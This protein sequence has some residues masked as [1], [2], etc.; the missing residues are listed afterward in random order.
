MTVRELE[1]IKFVGPATIESLRLIGYKDLESLKNANPDEMYQRERILRGQPIDRCQLYVY[2]YLVYI[3]NTENPEPKK[4]KW[5]YWK[6]K[7][8][9][10]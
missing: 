6:D 10:Y 9:N 7:V 2:R 3:A 8:S 4:M 5:W 1:K